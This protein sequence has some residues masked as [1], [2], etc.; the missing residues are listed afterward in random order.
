MNAVIGF[1][2]AFL[3]MIPLW[4]ALWRVQLLSG[5]T[6]IP[7]AFGLGLGLSATGFVV[8]RALGVPIRAYLWGEALACIAASLLLAMVGPRKAE[9]QNAASGTNTSNR[10]LVVIAFVMAAIGIAT[11]SRDQLVT[12]PY[13]TSDTWAIWNVRAAFIATEGPAWS[14]TFVAGVPLSHQDYPLLLPGA[15]T[16]LWS[17]VGDAPGPAGYLSVAVLLATAL[18][19]AGAV[20]DYVGPSAMVASLGVL[21][22]PEFVRQGATQHADLLV[23]FYSLLALVLIAGPSWTPW[24]MIAA[25]AA[26]GCAAWSKN[27]GLVLA[28]AL[29]MFATLQA[30]RVAKSA[31]SCR[32]SFRPDHRSWAIPC[33]PG[34]VQAAAGPR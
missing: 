10:W 28:I 16:R 26:C 33:R 22:T 7:A 31:Q 1:V 19:M 17:L 27:E 3:P 9:A 13:G 14:D 8:G 2:V 30:W 6:R 20:S 12:H 24:R 4:V 23:G 34:A 25:G 15:V 21:L 32:C 18:L 11:F 5:L 29:P